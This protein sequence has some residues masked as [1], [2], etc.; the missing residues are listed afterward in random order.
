MPDGVD[1]SV[2]TMKVCAVDTAANRLFAEPKIPQLVEREDS[3]LLPSDLRDAHIDG[4]GDFPSHGGEVSR[5]AHAI[6]P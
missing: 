5:Q 6:A 1:P 3:M 2:H 4:L